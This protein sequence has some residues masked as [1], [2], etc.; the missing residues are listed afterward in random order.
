MTTVVKNTTTCVSNK[1]FKVLYSDVD[2][3]EWY[4]EQFDF[5]IFSE[6]EIKEF[7]NEVRPEYYPCI[8]LLPEGGYDVMYLGVDLVEYWF[9]KIYTITI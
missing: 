4:R 3:E 1:K 2:F 8:P 7:F 9:R 5:S 6:S